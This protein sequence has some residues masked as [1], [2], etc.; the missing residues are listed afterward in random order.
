MQREMG[1]IMNSVKPRDVS[2][3]AA[4]IAD[5]EFAALVDRAKQATLWRVGD[6][7]ASQIQDALARREIRVM[8]S[9]RTKL[10]REGT[11]AARIR[12]EMFDVLTAG[13]EGKGEAEVFWDGC[14]AVRRSNWR[15]VAPDW[16]TVTCG[17]E[18]RYE[19]L[20]PR[21]FAVLRDMSERALIL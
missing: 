3:V 16:V 13:A 1:P 19:K 14:D 2:L 8:R 21:S 10:L 11:A 18:G 17:S 20:A 6:P 4:N 15:D 12:S 5:G 9:Y 7:R